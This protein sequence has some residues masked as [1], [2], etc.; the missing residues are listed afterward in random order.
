M[1]QCR[2]CFSRALSDSRLCGP[3][4]IEWDGYVQEYVQARSASN[5][6]GWTHADCDHANDYC[7][8][9]VSNTFR[10]STT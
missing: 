4:Q 6:E 5:G 8:A 9:T 10:P 2:S 1:A 7:T 3:C